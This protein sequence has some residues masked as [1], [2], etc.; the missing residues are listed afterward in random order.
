M[1]R[2]A[3][4]SFFLNAIVY[5]NFF[6]GHQGVTP[7][8]ISSFVPKRALSSSSR[9]EFIEILQKILNEG[10]EVLY[11]PKITFKNIFKKLFF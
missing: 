6:A 7:D 9:L 3:K 11:S 4:Y 8:G 1:P 2:D 5:L 10:L